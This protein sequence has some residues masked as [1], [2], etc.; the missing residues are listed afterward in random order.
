MPFVNA[1]AAAAGALTPNLLDPALLGGR[2]RIAMADFTLAT[3]TPG[4]YTAPIRLPAGARVICGFLNTTVTLGASA[5][6]AVGVPGTPG[7][8]RAAATF[9]AVDTMTFFALM[10]ST[11]QRLAAEE[12]IILTTATANL[13]ASG[14]LRIGF[15][16]VL[17]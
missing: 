2:V 7:R 1:G 6:I 3:D 14:T 4:T 9:T 11:G 15:F 8:Y 17:D 16:Y 5:T 13:P 10:A 12:Q